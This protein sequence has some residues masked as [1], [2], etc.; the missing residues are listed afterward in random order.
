MRHHTE[1][2]WRMAGRLAVVLAAIACTLLWAGPAEAQSTEAG[3]SG[4]TVDGNPGHQ[5]H[6][7]VWNYGVSAETSQV[8]VTVTLVD[9]A[10]SFIYGFADANASKAGHQ[11]NLSSTV[12]AVSIQ[13][14][15]EAGTQVE[16]E[17]VIYKGVAS[18]FGLRA[19]ASLFGMFQAGNENTMGS[20][21]SDG[22]TMWVAD[23]GDDK[24][25]AYRL[26][27]GA[28]D[29][30]KDFDTLS[31]A[32]NQDPTGIWSDSETMWVADSVDEKIYAYRMSDRSRN[33]SRDIETLTEAGNRNPT[34]LWSDGRTIWVADSAD[35]QLYAYGLADG[36]RRPDREFISLEGGLANQPSGIW[37]DGV[38]MWVAELENRKI[39]AYRMSDKAREPSKEFDTLRG[40]G[41][42][43]P[44][45]LWSDGETIYVVGSS[46]GGI[47]GFN[48]SVPG[49]L[50]LGSITLNGE[51]VSGVSAA[52]RSYTLSDTVPLTADV[53]IAATASATGSS[54]D[55]SHPDVISGTTGHQIAL[56]EGGNLIQLY[57]R[58]LAT[59]RTYELN[60]SGGDAPGDSDS[61]A[62]IQVDEDDDGAV[63]QFRGE[64]QEVTDGRDFD[65]I[66]VTLEADQ[67][68][69]IIL[70][71][72]RYGDSDRTL[73]PPASGVFSMD[74]FHD[75]AD[76]LGVAVSSGIEG[77]ARALFQPTSAGNYQVVVAGAQADDTGTYDLRVRP[78]EDDH[79]PDGIETG[80]TISFPTDS[81]LAHY[82]SAAVTG[83]INYEFDDDWFQASDLA[84]GRS[85]VIEARHGVGDEPRTG[86]R[87][88]FVEV[89][90]AEGDKVEVEPDLN[91]YIFTPQSAQDYYIRVYS[92]QRDRSRYTL[93]L[94]P[95]LSLSG[96]LLV[97]DSL[98]VDPTDIYDPDGT[99]R[100]TRNDSW[101]YTWRRTDASG[102]VERIR[103]ARGTS[104]QLTDDDADHTITARVCYK[105]DGN[106]RVYDCRY[107]H[108]QPVRGAVT[109]PSSWD[110]VP[111]GLDAGD[112]FRLL[113]VSKDTR[114]ATETD[115]AV[116][117]AWAQGQVT[118]GHDD[119]QTYADH[120]A[121][122]GSTS[123]ISARVNTLTRFTGD[124]EGIPIYWLG[125]RKAADHYKDFYDGTWDWSNPVTLSDGTSSA[126]AGRTIWT[127]T[128]QS[129]YEDTSGSTRYGLGNS[130]VTAGNPALRTGGN[131]L[132]NILTGSVSRKQMYIL[133]YPFEV[134]AATSMQQGNQP[135]TGRP[136]ISGAHNVGDTVTADVTG[137]ADADGLTGVAFSYQWLSGDSELS[138]ETN[139]SYTLTGTD[140]GQAVAVRVTFTD[141]AGNEEVLTSEGIYPIMTA[142]ENTP[143]TGQP[144]ISGT[145]LVGQTLAAGVTGIADADGL[146]DVSYSYQW[147]AGS[148]PIADATSDTYT[149]T[150]AELSKAITV[151]VRF[152]DNGGNEETLTSAA[153]T[154]VTAAPNSAAT[155]QPQV[156]G[157]ALVGARLSVDTSGIADADG[158]SGAQYR[159]QWLTSE[160]GADTEIAGATGSS[161]R[162]TWR[163]DG[164]SIKVRVSFTDDGGNEESLTSPALHPVRPSGLAAA[165]SGETVVLSWE[166]PTGF[167]LLFDYRILR[168]APE[169]G[170]N[171]PVVSTDT[172][173]SAT[174]YTDSDVEPGVLYRY[175]V[176]AANYWNQLSPASE[177]V[178]IRIPQPDAVANTPATGLPTISGIPQVGQTL[179]ASV[180][181][182][183]DRDGL[184]DAAY[185]YQWLADNAAITGAT[186]AAY[187]LTS[188]EQGKTVNVAVTFTD[189]AG[190]A[191]S[192]TSAATAAVKPAN[193]PAT[194]QPTISGTALVGETLTADTS[195][196]D[197]EDGLTN[198]SFSYQWM[199]D[200]VGIAGATAASYTLTSSEE[201]K[202]IKVRVS[203]TDDAGNEESLTSAATAA[204]ASPP[205]P[206]TASIHDAPESHDRENSFT[207]E[208]RFSETPGPDF[209]YEALRD[210]AFTATGGTVTNARRLDPPG[211]V[212]WEIT[213]EPSSDAEVSI[214]LPE[215][216]DCDDQG[217]ICTADGRMLS[218]EAAL[219]VAGPEEEE[220][221]TPPEN[222]PATGAPAI[223]G[224]AQVGETLTANTSG[225]ADADGLDNASFSYQWIRNDGS[226]D[227]DIQDATGST[228]TLTSADEGK[229]VKVRVS[230]TDDAGNDETLASEAT[231]DVAAAP[232]RAATGTPTISG[233]VQVGET[234]T[235]DTS[236][237]A[238]EDGLDRAS[239]SYQW[240]AGGTDIDGASGS[241]YTL[242]STQQGKTVQVRVSFTD[243][244]GNQEYLTSAPTGAVAA[245]PSPL[246]VSLT[247]DAPASHDGSTAFTF[248]IRFSEEPDPD[249]SY[250]TLRDHAFTATGGSV[251]T[252]QRL[253]K[254][255]ISNIGWRITVE[256]GGNGDV[257]IVLPV[258]TDCDADGA[259]CTGDG[260]K[261]SNSLNFTVSGPG[262]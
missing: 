116:Y 63:H 12:T 60:V 183:A 181:A 193:T 164:K 230:F 148:D 173:N 248:E 32:G 41:I 139:A 8:T 206:L 199:A 47:F 178:E 144:T 180:T 50:D 186:A 5:T 95:P 37:S 105:A 118:R 234:L 119:I 123:A 76:A 259:V 150:A 128:N 195:G 48:M 258:T 53:T 223:S 149:L 171:E 75:G 2:A 99:S 103:G 245:A 68:Y 7:I 6:S 109:V 22:E 45:G 194:G 44:R 191:E 189:D 94:H 113:M 84:P 240:I 3:V 251:K 115:I 72:G 155:G 20:I 66:N 161:Y 160:D 198:V 168:E 142:T 130:T 153:T 151:R 179:T 17:L 246:T 159:Y 77:R 205:T 89:Y 16:T 18:V 107:S 215:T 255:P 192:L 152:T 209:S 126:F 228:Y 166:P 165:V 69:A 210:H 141:D 132:D 127:G 93:Y 260:R 176:Q 214:V 86:R 38:T 146:E 58:G 91:R 56:D 156:V 213:V 147:L 71:G 106:Y 184:D 236:V 35:N 145:A 185:A 98:S 200:D 154:A 204:V 217:A 10:A 40:V 102:N 218:A 73:H 104:F 238:D 208:L 231:G 252:A 79:Y 170:G 227:T 177:A 19:D 257:T 134:G 49:E 138:G 133:S 65:W 207:F 203:F 262:S 52:E 78:Y 51:E 175:R 242:T 90:D 220:E 74:M 163:E 216:T 36:K 182:I 23:T 167:A 82:P 117:N 29:S 212:R 110:R 239:F 249:F 15:S 244:A 131:T 21:W 129:G 232:N 57:V 67:L 92:H 137:I 243:N 28:Y 256:P 157:S 62:R 11:V 96:N 250:K 125:G 201:G 42:R 221:R 225:I 172:G 111:S 101:R 196:I 188:G 83:R 13:V 70:K 88:L 100:V 108:S 226:A 87:H 261:L 254:D 46:R 14:T 124:D 120:F 224:T 235:A 140:F 9:A 187:T 247:A 233:T 24:L 190:N 229:T 61:K 39:Y 121:V 211:N 80:S 158:L 219:T 237:I 33:P 114:S 97:G 64:I 241:S 26:A 253:Q 112:Q 55:F 174:S 222:S 54:V 31:A 27:G 25:Y 169:L 81:S 143:A 4:V 135:A 136:V 202:A 43:S 85:Y 59:Y 34:G 122:L 30:D 1:F 197:E 162:L